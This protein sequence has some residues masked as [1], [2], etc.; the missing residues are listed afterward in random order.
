MIFDYP[1]WTA[2]LVG[3]GLIG[4]AAAL[5]LLGLGRIAGISGI[6]G[7]LM[8]VRR[9]EISI[10]LSFLAGLVLIPLIAVRAGFQTDIQITENPVLLISAG[11]L[12]GIGTRLGNG[13]TSGHGVCGMTRVSKRSLV[14]VGVFMAVA[15]VVASLIRPMLG[16]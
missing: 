7:A 10:E 12:V 2:G 8:D 3:G 9:P 6:A 1:A 16:A 14:S 4:L 13:C 15:A 5:Y 11:L